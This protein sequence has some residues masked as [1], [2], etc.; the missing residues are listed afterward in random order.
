METNDITQ[1][2][3]KLVGLAEDIPPMNKDLKVF[4]NG[5]YSHKAKKLIETDDLAYMGFK[6]YDY[7]ENANNT[8]LFESINDS[9]YK[10]NFE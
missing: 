9:G 5:T 1:I 3:S 2:I 10:Y 6:N 8:K 4:R 7:I